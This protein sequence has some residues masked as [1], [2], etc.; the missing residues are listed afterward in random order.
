MIGGFWCH[1]RRLKPS[2][3]DVEFEGM[4]SESEELTNSFTERERITTAIFRDDHSDLDGI[5]MTHHLRGVET[6]Q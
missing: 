4:D 5:E 1:W 6:L 2:P 3:E